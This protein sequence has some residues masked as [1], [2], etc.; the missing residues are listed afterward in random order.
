MTERRRE[1]L[2]QLTTVQNQPWN[3]TRDLMTITGFMSDDEVVAH[4]A[5]WAEPPTS[6]VARQPKARRTR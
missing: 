6:W 5:R 2:T 3:D 4:I 1:L